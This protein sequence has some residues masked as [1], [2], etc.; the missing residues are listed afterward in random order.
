MHTELTA[1]LRFSLPLRLAGCRRLFLHFIFVLF[2]FLITSRILEQDWDN[3]IKTFLM[4]R[5]NICMLI[6]MLQRNVSLSLNIWD[7]YALMM[8]SSWA[9]YVPTVLKTQYW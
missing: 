1:A 7:I 3:L 5:P 8:Q 2:F 4:S 9:D 6:N